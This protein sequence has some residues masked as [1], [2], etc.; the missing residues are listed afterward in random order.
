MEQ[1]YTGVGARN[2]PE[3]ILQRMRTLAT[4]FKLLI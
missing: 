3:P 2:T 4:I 1:Y